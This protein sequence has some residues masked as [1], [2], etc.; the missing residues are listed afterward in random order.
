M[1]D[2]ETCKTT[3]SG[4]VALV[5][6]PNVGK[7]TLL[8]ALVGQKIAATTPK[9]QTTRHRILGIVTL[10][11]AQII[12]IDL[13]GLHTRQPHLINR[14]MNTVAIGSMQDA[15]VLAVMVDASRWT[16]DDEFVL[17]QVAA[18]NRPFVLLLN[19]IDQM[20]DKK[21]LLP[22]IADLRER[23]GTDEIV[24]ISA[25]RSENL[26]AVVDALLRYLPEGPFLFPEDE[27]TD[28]SLKFIIS[29][30]IREKIFLLTNREV[31]YSTAVH[32]EAFEDQGKL[33]RID[34]LIWVERPSHK[35]IIIGRKGQLIKEIGMRARKEIE[36]LLGKKVH[37]QLWV[38]VRKDWQDDVRSLKDIGIEQ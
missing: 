30:L 17:E 32:I 35:K 6:R 12:F 22:L 3:R 11:C 37:L 16:P 23:F 27:V 5:G 38:K 36:E 9:P 33:V 19:K 24:P 8:N 21:R 15:D 1:D 13:P 25:L 28:R 10:E 4:F 18:A 20:K 34:A 2:K 14:A 29:E 7:S 26:Q 31:P